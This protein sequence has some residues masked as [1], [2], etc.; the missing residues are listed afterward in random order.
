MFKEM[1]LSKIRAEL[2]QYFEIL[3]SIMQLWNT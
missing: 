2:Q 1:I 3:L